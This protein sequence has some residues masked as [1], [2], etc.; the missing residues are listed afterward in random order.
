MGYSPWGC[1]ESHRTELLTLSLSLCLQP[2]L[3]A[4]MLSFCVLRA[5]E[6]LSS[7][8]TFALGTSSSWSLFFIVLMPAHPQGSASSHV[9]WKPSLTFQV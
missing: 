1:K 2:T 5:Q 7:L 6:P 4:A 3:L 9:F 8:W